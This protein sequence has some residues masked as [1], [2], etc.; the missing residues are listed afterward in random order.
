MKREIGIK[1]TVNRQMAISLFI[2]ED[3]DGKV[4]RASSEYGKTI[5]Q[6]NNPLCL[7]CV[8]QKECKYFN[9]I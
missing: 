6:N 4:Y 7:V 2:G 9:F 1:N 5:C 3:G 8:I